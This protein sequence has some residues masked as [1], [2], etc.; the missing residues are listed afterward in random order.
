M[1]VN[2]KAFMPLI[3]DASQS[4]NYAFQALQAAK[5]KRESDYS[6]DINKSKEFLIDAHKKQTEILN[7]DAAGS[8]TDINIFLIHAMDHV[9]NAQVMHDLIKELAEIHLSKNN[10]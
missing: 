3:M 9:S 6:V 4:K 7:I 8:N 1:E 2:V 5:D 10:N